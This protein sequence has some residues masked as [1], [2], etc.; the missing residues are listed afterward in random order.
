M[1]MKFTRKWEA[2]WS[3]ISEGRNGVSEASSNVWGLG[4]K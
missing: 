2:S 1:F 4:Q 3:L